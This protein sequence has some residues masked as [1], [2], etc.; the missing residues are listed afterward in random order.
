MVDVRLD[1]PAPRFALV[2]RRPASYLQGMRRGRFGEYR[3]ELARQ[4]LHR[5]AVYEAVEGVTLAAAAAKAR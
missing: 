3:S 1:T 5:H 4:G 2:G